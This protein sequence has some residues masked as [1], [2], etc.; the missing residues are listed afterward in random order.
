MGDFVQSLERLLDVD[1]KLVIP[2]HGQPA[3]RPREFIQ[4]QLDH[5][6]W[7]EAK[8]RQAYEAGASTFEELLAQGY[9]DVPPASLVWARHTLDAH[10][11]KLGIEHDGSVEG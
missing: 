10:L 8:I 5:R 9:D 1:C 3:G 11:A 6:L 2:A 7:R 4:Q